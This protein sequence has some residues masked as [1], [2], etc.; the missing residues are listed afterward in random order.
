MYR[1]VVGEKAIADA[2]RGS[3]LG[4]RYAL[5]ERETD[6]PIGTTYSARDSVRGAAVTVDSIVIERTSPS[7]LLTMLQ[8]ALEPTRA[9]RHPNLAAVLDYGYEPGFGG[10][11][12]QDYVEGTTIAETIRQAPPS[13]E[14]SIE[15]AKTVLSILTTAHTRN[16]AHGGISS[17]NVVL[18]QPW[19]SDVLDPRETRVRNLG[20][21]R[22]RNR[23]LADA[24]DTSPMH[25]IGEATFLSPEQC[26][27]DS[28][29]ARSDVYACGCLLYLMCT[30]K[31]PFVG[32]SPVGIV[33]RQV[34]E[35]PVPPSAL[36]DQV[37]LE[38]EQAI[39]RALEKDPEKRF[40]NA[41]TFLHALPE[42]SGLHSPR[43]SERPRGS[44][45]P[46]VRAKIPTAGRPSDRPLADPTGSS[47]EA[48]ESFF[49]PRK[50]P[51]IAAE[52]AVR[53][54]APIVVA[55]TS[56]D[57]QPI[58]SDELPMSIPEQPVL[59]V[60]R[61]KPSSKRSRSLMLWLSGIAVVIM[62]SWLALC[63]ASNSDTDSENGTQKLTRESTK[64][65]RS[66]SSA[67]APSTKGPASSKEIEM[68]EPAKQV[69][70]AAGSA[71]GTAALQ[72]DIS[73]DSPR[74]TVR[75]RTSS[76][77]RSSSTRSRAPKARRS[78]TRI[79]AP[80]VAAEPAT[81]EIQAAPPRPIKPKPTP[82]Q[83]R[84][85]GVEPNPYL[86]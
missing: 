84:L 52:L 16:I 55:A 15:I 42:I 7:E 73:N 35:A 6:S 71:A 13:L 29:D 33:L 67:S 65:S 79:T 26:Q 61:D 23:L 34:G 10:Y 1:V 30:G 43:H 83:P 74:K 68:P 48:R 9:L 4:G 11:V 82:S 18:A 85:G 31:P 12:V 8:E 69:D 21:S 17:T 36:N 32:D 70:V 39:L 76:V 56:V 44:S 24:I 22:I 25:D 46:T 37:P 19:G 63:T 62:S 78:S 38:L 14:K 28:Y 5:K 53:V 59:T 77:R 51:P 45:E 86:N 47:H 54:P 80:S 58:E 66:E 57:A 72:E 3:V 81:P 40:A 41:E 60:W 75:R 49:R 64:P 2:V 50:P 27:A 20:M